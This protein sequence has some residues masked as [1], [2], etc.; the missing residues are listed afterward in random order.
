MDTQKIIRELD[1]ISKA[2]KEQEQKRARLEGE[3]ATIMKRLKE[4]FEVD[5]IR[6]AKR[7]LKEMETN[8]AEME[9]ELETK[10]NE[11]VEMI[12]DGII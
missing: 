7:K 11:L 4:E 9:K 12:P 2:I 10:Y 6:E 5:S 8:K 3:E 1:S